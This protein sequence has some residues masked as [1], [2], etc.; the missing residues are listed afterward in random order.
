MCGR[1]TQFY[2]WDEIQKAMKLLPH[3]PNLRPCY[4]IA[5]TTMIDVVVAGNGEQLLM[6]M[7]WGL[8]P[9]WWKKSLRTLP[10]PVSASEIVIPS[11]P[12]S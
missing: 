1:F 5:P 2:S 4:N 7:R 12:E 10:D 9:D 3:A 6:P 11:H 8:V